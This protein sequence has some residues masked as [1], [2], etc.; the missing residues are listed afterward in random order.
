MKATSPFTA[1]WILI[2]SGDMGNTGTHA[3][4]PFST[5]REDGPVEHASHSEHD[6]GDGQG[7]VGGDRRGRVRDAVPG[8]PGDRLVRGS[9]RET[10]LRISHGEQAGGDQPGAEDPDE[11][12]RRSPPDS[13]GEGA[14]DAGG[15]SESAETREHERHDLD[16]AGTTASWLIGCG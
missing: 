15:Q 16:P 5:A 12:R 7:T 14:L 8:H 13:L 3:V 4:A 1:I 2:Q 6:C 10:A 9:D 11:D